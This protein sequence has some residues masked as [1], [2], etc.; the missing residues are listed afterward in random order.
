MFYLVNW[1]IGN[2]HKQS[3]IKIH[4]SEENT[5]ENVIREMSAILFW[6][7]CTNIARTIVTQG[8][9]QLFSGA[10]VW[11]LWR[12]LTGTCGIMEWLD[13]QRMTEPSAGRYKKKMPTL[14][15]RGHFKYRSASSH[16]ASCLQI[17][18]CNVISSLFLIWVIFPAQAYHGTFQNFVDMSRNN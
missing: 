9:E 3:L 12:E 11:V 6:H 17:S 14:A 1:I 5:C 15:E 16:T 4:F 18:V 13:V 10:S 2:T 7:H 8:S